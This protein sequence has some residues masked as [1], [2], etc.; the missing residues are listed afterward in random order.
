MSPPGGETAHQ[1]SR[2]VEP[3]QVD[4]AAVERGQ[5]Y[6]SP[7]IER[8]VRSQGGPSWNAPDV[9]DWVR[10]VLDAAGRTT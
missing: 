6:L 10:G 1:G 3:P 8:L 9:R 4:D 5:A 2:E 7:I